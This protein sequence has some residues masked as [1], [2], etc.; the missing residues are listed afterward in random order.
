[1]QAILPKI[2]DLS[3]NLNY[4][5]DLRNFLYK[6]LTK[7]GYKIQKPQG[8]FYLFPESLEKDDVSFIKTAVKFGILLVP[9]SGFGIPSYFRLS[10]AVDKNMAKRSLVAFEKLFN[11]YKKNK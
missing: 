3:I 4:Y 6:E 1:M 11:Y 8:A 5:H 9:G 10:Y 7:I 2:F